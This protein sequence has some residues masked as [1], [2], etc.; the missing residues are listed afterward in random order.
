M[1][2]SQKIPAP[3]F[4]PNHRPPPKKSGAW[5]IGERLNIVGNALRTRPFFLGRILLCLFFDQKR[6]NKVFVL[7]LLFFF[8]GC[9]GECISQGRTGEKEAGGRWSPLPSPPQGGRETGPETTAGK[10]G[11]R[12]GD[13]FIVLPGISARLAHTKKLFSL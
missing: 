11:E 9:E 13:L 4:L 2:S 5:G 3:S 1:A 12:K 7:T 10:K 8:S 6:P